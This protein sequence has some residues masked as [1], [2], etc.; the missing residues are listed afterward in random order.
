MGVVKFSDGKYQRCM[1]VIT[2][3]TARKPMPILWWF[4]GAG[5]NAAHCGNQRDLVSLAESTG[6]AYICGEAT[7]NVF[8]QVSRNLRCEPCVHFWMQHG[9]CVFWIYRQLL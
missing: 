6:F 2:P 9:K 8:G 5:G 1:S 3:S 4:H 7:Q